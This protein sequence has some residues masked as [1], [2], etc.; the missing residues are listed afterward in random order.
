M[1]SENIVL[2]DVMLSITAQREITLQTHVRV[3]PEATCSTSSARTC[4]HL[5]SRKQIRVKKRGIPFVTKD[6]IYHG[7]KM[8]FRC[9]YFLLCV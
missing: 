8:L 4:N 1:H 5:D 7:Y 3:N 9:T 2:R 6:N